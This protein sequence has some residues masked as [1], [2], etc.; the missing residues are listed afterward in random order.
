VPPSMC[1]SWSSLAFARSAS[2]WP[3][4]PRRVVSVVGL[5]SSSHR[6]PSRI[7]NWGGTNASTYRLSRRRWAHI[8][9][10][11]MPRRRKVKLPPRIALPA[12]E[13]N[14]KIMSMLRSLKECAKLQ[15]VRLVHVGS[16]GQEPNWFAQP[17]PSRISDACR[18]AFVAAFA[19][20]RK[21]FDLLWGRN[22]AIPLP[23]EE[24]AAEQ[25]GPSPRRAGDCISAE[26]ETAPEPR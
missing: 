5:A 1:L 21:E 15:G 23:E 25:P 24:S 9:P 26:Q 6:R 19:R 13:L 16:F 14:G 8:A 18:R 3:R 7:E 17:L 4:S 10:A 2:L 12:S 11:A 20:V 22:P